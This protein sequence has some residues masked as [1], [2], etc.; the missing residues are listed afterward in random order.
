MKNE[1]THGYGAVGFRKTVINK[2]YFLIVFSVLLP[3]S[4]VMFR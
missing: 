4:V 2:N 1:K 3:F